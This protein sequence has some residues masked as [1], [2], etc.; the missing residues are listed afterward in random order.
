MS[1]G[2]I[3]SN[4]TIFKYKII[5]NIKPS[6]ADGLTDVDRNYLIFV[7]K[8]VNSHVQ[9]RLAAIRATVAGTAT[10]MAESSDLAASSASFL[11]A[12][13]FAFSAADKIKMRSKLIALNV[14]SSLLCTLYK[15]YL[16]ST[17][18]S[19]PSAVIKLVKTSCAVL[20]T[21]VSVLSAPAH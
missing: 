13:S 2:F 17:P 4:L 19:A 3:V 18:F 15:P 6:T 12:S 1:I 5:Q 14:S 8:G 9:K 20:S 16:I 7:L 21:V 10:F 11:A